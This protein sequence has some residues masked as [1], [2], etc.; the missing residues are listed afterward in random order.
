MRWTLFAFLAWRFSGMI[1]PVAGDDDPKVDV[2]SRRFTS[3]SRAPVFTLGSP[4]S[5]TTLLYHMLLSAGGFARFRA[6]THVFSVLSPRFGGLLTPRDRRQALA[7]WLRSPYQALTGL[8]EEEVRATIERD[9][10]HAGDFL[11]LVMQAMAEKQQVARW[12]ETTPSHLLHMREIKA[13]IPDALFVHVVRDGR[14]VAASL[15]RQG[16]IRPFP[17]D[18]PVL[19]AAAYWDWMVRRGRR[20]GV[21]LGDDYIE[22]RY[23]ALIESPREVFAKLSAFIGQALDWDEVRRVGIGSVAAP[24]TSFPGAA[25]AFHGR[26]RSVLAADDARDVDAMLRETLRL[27]GYAS[28]GAPPSMSLT[29]RR[30]AYAARF[31][32]R[33]WGK[34][35]TPLQRR[36]TDLGLYMANGP[37]ASR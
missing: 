10:Q 32:A 23:E 3:R 7:V 22:V 33:D 12:A 27:L 36:F 21:A 29:A 8:T 20:E 35:R 25:G 5:G 2:T 30:R 15:A 26:W 17:F 6:E 34:R 9:C 13:L 14:D 37:V 28:E 1:R 18:R 11:R 31:A 16:W 24:N 4:R 19:A